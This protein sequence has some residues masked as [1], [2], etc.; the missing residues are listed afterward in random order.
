MDVEKLFRSKLF[1]FSRNLGSK[2]SYSNSHPNDLII[3]NARIYTANIYRS[4]LHKITDFFMGREYQIWWGDLNLSKDLCELREIAI[5]MDSDLVI[6]TEFGQRVL[7][8]FG[9]ANYDKV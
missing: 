5:E 2:S 6:T 7:Q 4:Y 8:I 1:P 3:F 9:N